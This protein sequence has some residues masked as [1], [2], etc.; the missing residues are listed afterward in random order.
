MDTKL[1]VVIIVGLLVL[2]AIADTYITAKYKINK[3]DKKDKK[4]NK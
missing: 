1:F 2:F 4:D 3:K